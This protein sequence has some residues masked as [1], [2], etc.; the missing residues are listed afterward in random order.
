LVLGA[1]G[2]ANPSWRSKLHWPATDAFALIWLLREDV[3]HGTVRHLRNPFN[4]DLPAHVGT[5]GVE[6]ETR[7]GEQMYGILHDFA[8]RGSGHS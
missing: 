7:V 2:L 5:D 3:P 8:R 1:A 6:I 4:Q